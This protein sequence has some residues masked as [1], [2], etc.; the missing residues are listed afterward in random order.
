MP[1]VAAALARA[2][3]TAG[4]FPLALASGAVAAAALMAL[5]EG[6]ER[7]W[8][9][10][11][12]V[13]AVLGL[14]LFTA[15]TTAA[16]RRGLEG[17]RRWLPAAIL[18]PTL[19][20]FFVAA[21]GWTDRQLALRFV[22][23]LVGAHLLVAVLGFGG[24]REQRAF[25]QHNRLLFL[26]FLLAALYAT[27]LWVGL[28]VA[29]LAVDKLLGVDVP[30]E[31]Y[32][33]LIALLAF[34]FHPWFLLARVPDDLQTLDRDDYPLGLKV[35][36]QFVLIPLVTVYLL[37]LTAYLGR[38]LI[39][40]TWPS[41]WIGWLVSSVSVAGVLAL[42]LVHPIRDREDSRWVN[43]Y[44]RWFFVALL[45]SL[46]MLLVAVGKRIGQYGFTEPRYFLLVLAL[47]LTALAGYYAVTGSRSI[48]L[49]PATLCLLAGLTAVGPWSAFAVS[50]RSQLGRLGAILA[51]NGMGVAGAARRATGAVP[52]GDERELSA[53]LAYLRQGHGVDAVQA[54]LGVAADSV[55]AWAGG[56]RSPEGNGQVEIAAMRWLG[57]EF[58]YRWSA[59][60]GPMFA[61]GLREPQ[62]VE[63]AGF[64]RLVPIS[65][66]PG[67]AVALG[68]D[69]LTLAAAAGLRSVS[70]RRG[71]VTLL[72]L[73]LAGPVEGA[74]AET[75]PP[76]A[77]RQ[78]AAPPPID[79]EG[80]GLVVRM[81]LQHVT[82]ERRGDGS[83]TLNGV[84]GFLLLRGA[85]GA[86]R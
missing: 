26:G 64:D 44:G 18:V 25:W 30:N 86:P 22:Q 75:G 36:T 49:I 82:G 8:K 14:P 2:R 23:L 59:V 41:G 51:A 39:T 52:P 19:A 12:L 27:V 80:A 58:R 77:D 24:D 7:D 11:L 60:A 61:M 69:S 13:T 56:D 48:R 45:P 65:L 15:L 43:A 63:V 38:V 74:L 54:A 40:R 37:I 85:A 28:A 1:A 16:E 71:E 42:L 20:L 55:R 33:H 70:V 3:R 4:R 83:V 53:V 73:D 57:L 6:P 31:F 72:T 81:V 66:G 9:V 79:Q 50:H 84:S 47:W 46:G 78:W 10:R 34:G 17:V 29:L 67:G 68:I 32:P 76:S 35:F 62:V 5:I 21:G